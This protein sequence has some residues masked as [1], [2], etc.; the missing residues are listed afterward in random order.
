VKQ[1]NSLNSDII[2]EE[3]S[4]FYLD[5]IETVSRENSTFSFET[6]VR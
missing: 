5:Y 4:I 1:T 2:S 3:A 6:V